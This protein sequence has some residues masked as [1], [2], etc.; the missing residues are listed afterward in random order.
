MNI[1]EKTYQSRGYWI[2]ENL[3]YKHV[4]FRTVKIAHIINRLSR[5][6]QC[7]LLDI[8]CGPETLSTLLEPNINYFGIDIAIHSPKQNLIELD[9][10]H[11]PI[12][13]REKSFD[14]VVAAG[15]FE[16][17]GDQYEKKYSEIQ[18]LLKPGGKFIVTYMNMKHCTKP[19]FPT[20]NYITSI[21][22]FKADLRKY[23]HV[24]HS[25]P[26]YYSNQPGDLT[27]SMIR[28][29]QLHLNVNIPLLADKYGVNYIY[30]TGPKKVTP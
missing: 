9:I 24:Y 14:F 5:G 6:K 4:Y 3:R 15:L 11:N 16:Y 23:F 19:Y 30:I 18:R 20:W 21:E 2:E 17:L 12:E 8:G 29:L 13:F 22:R 25:F 7:D 28:K 10:V 27:G 1:R 26:S